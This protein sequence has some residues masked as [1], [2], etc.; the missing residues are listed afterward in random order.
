MVT[1]EKAKQKADEIMR[2]IIQNQ[3]L[4]DY[5]SCYTNEGKLGLKEFMNKMCR[6]V[7]GPNKKEVLLINVNYYI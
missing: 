3:K 2:V 7:V 5:S 6:K 1:K 4:E